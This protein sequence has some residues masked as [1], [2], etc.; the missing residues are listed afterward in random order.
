VTS[1]LEFVLAELPPPPARVLEVGCGTEGGLVEALLGAGYQAVG[2]DP[3]AP[4]RP[5]FRQ[6]PFEDFEESDTFDAAVASRV[7]HH[8]ARLEPV[9]DKVAELAP[10]LVMQEFAW[11]RIDVPTQRW[12]EA[13]RRRLEADGEDPSGPLE[14]DEW[15]ARH[16]DLHPA[17]VV[18][19]ELESRYETQ[20]LEERPYFHLW[21]EHPAT[22]A[23][24][25][26]LIARGEIQPIG[27]RYTGVRLSERPDPRDAS[28]VH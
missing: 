20:F 5:P 8:V 28:P 21:L 11:E 14:L 4:D 23:V 16:M 26:E 17:T 15:R 9:L 13:Q 6:V 7:F 19:R 24:E 22:E 27:V 12:Y 1:F 25:A 18:L 10:L 2:V 3:D